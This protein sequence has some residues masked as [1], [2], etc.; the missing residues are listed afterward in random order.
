MIG[1]GEEVGEGMEW[2]RGC[3]EEEGGGGGEREWAF[4]KKSQHSHVKRSQ[5]SQTQG[6]LGLPA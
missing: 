4:L 3:R 6:A 1:Q 5:A 2:G